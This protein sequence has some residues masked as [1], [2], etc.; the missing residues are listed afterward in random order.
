MFRRFL[1][2]TDPVASFR[3]LADAGAGGHLIVHSRDPEV[4]AAL[5]AAGVAGT[6][7]APQAGDVFGAFASNADGTKIDFYVRRSLSYRVDLGEGGG[8]TAEVRSRP[9]T[10]R[11]SIPRATCSGRIRERARAGG[12]AGVR[13]GVLRPR[14]RI[15]GRHP[16]R[17]ATGP[18]APR[19]RGLSVFSTYVQTAPGTTSELALQ[20]QRAD[21]WTGDELG[22]TYLLRIRAQQTVL[23][24]R[25][26]ITIQAPPGTDI[27][28]AT[29][30]MQ[31]DGGRATWEGDSPPCRTSR[32]GSSGRR[33]AASGTGSRRRCS[34]TEG[35][36]RQGM[37]DRL[38]G[39]VLP[40]SIVEAGIS[41]TSF[42]AALDLVVAERVAGARC[43]LPSVTVSDGLKSPEGKATIPS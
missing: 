39:G 8:S 19:E 7:E 35:R 14:L 30:G 18:R 43:R 31:V 21:A 16:R 24:T 27:V 29:P 5:E 10:R 2:G 41:T 33:S 4:Q 26:T 11:P 38:S 17:E 34:A 20:L 9:R 12:V 32:S 25:G 6:V 40:D 23:P 28:D 36:F 1:A 13:L 15:P 3:A 42:L 37:T 22:G